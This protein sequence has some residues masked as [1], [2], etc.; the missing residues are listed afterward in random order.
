MNIL[1]FSGKSKKTLGDKFWD[2]VVITASDSSQKK[3]YEDQINEKLKRKEIPSDLPYLIFA[4][5]PGTR[6]G[7]TEVAT[8]INLMICNLLSL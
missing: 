4:D 7:M 1:F 8:Y 2:A 6:A 5:P 3:A